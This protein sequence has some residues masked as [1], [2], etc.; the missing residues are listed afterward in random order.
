VTRVERGTPVPTLLSRLLLAAMEQKPEP[1]ALV[2]LAAVCLSLFVLD[3]MR[4]LL[5]CI[6]RQ[7]PGAC[8]TL[9]VL[10]HR[11]AQTAHAHC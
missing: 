5:E 1:M 3:F 9:R 4:S 8:C 10:Q 7:K 11:R 2:M 6:N